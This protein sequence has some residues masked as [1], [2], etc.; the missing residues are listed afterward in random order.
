MRLRESVRALIID[1]D[2]RVL[3]VRFDW[4]G[5]EPTGGFWANPKARSTTPTCAGSSTSSRFRK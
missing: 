1:P 3:L 4:P 5:L 2:D